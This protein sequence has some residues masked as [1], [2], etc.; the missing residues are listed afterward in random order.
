MNVR[1]EGIIVRLLCERK[2][3]KKT[4]V[5]FVNKP[6]VGNQRNFND[7]LFAACAYRIAHAYVQH[8]TCALVYYNYYYYY[9][10]YYNAPQ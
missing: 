3:Q 8:V 5:Y 4:Q 6:L 2:V 1:S 9:Y 10:Y 7:V